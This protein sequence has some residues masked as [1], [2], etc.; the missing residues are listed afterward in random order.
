M[1][2]R[3]KYASKD[4]ENGSCYGVASHDCDGGKMEIFADDELDRVHVD[5]IDVAACRRMLMVMVLV[6]VFVELA[7]VQEAVPK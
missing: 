6:D 4:D 2:Q 7:K 1:V 5:S 3:G